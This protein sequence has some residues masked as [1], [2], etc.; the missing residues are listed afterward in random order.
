MSARP[1][2]GQ[3]RALHE[4]FV[5][6]TRRAATMLNYLCES[7]VVEMEV[8]PV[9]ILTPAELRS[10]LETR[11][12][13]VAVCG[14]ELIYNGHIEGCAQIVFPPPSSTMLVETLATER[15]RRLDRDQ[16]EMKT[17]SEV[18]N[19]LF[20]GLMGS[21]MA[22]FDEDI[23]YMPPFYRQGP[24]SEILPPLDNSDR[25]TAVLGR[26]DVTIANEGW[27]EEIFIFFQVEQFPRI[28]AGLESSE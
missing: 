15:R 18:G 13:T 20:N 25:M 10:H 28:L 24:L 8:G 3:I 9:E 1:T 27:Q 2:P 7:A 14:M 22:N 12:G 21:L 17:L 11:L 4:W 16:V 23:T 26:T 19:I 6:G 5:L